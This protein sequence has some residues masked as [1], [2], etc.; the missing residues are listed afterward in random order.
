MLGVQINDLIVDWSFD[1]SGV[2]G[3]LLTWYMQRGVTMIILKIE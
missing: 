2:G 3:V 1:T